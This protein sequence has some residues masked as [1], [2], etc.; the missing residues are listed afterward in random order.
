MLWFNPPVRHRPASVVPARASGAG[1]DGPGCCSRPRSGRPS[2]FC[3]SCGRSD[4]SGGAAPHFVDD[5]PPSGIDHRYDG[6]FEYFVGGGVAA[7]DCDGDGRDELFLAGGTEP[8]ALYHNDSPTGG[9]LRFSAAAVTR[10]RPHRRRPAPTPSTSTAT[11]TT[12]LVVLRRGGDVVLRG[13]GDCRFEPANQQLGIDVPP[14]WTTAFSAT[15]EGTNALPTLAFGRYLVPGQ[16]TCD[17]SWLVRPESASGTALRRACSRSRRATAPC[18]C[19]SAT[20]ATPDTATCASRTTGTTTWTVRSSCAGSSRASL[21][22]STPRPTAGSPCRS[23]AWASP[24]RTSPAT[25]GR[26]CSSPARATTSCRRSPPARPVRPSRT[27]PS[28]AA[29]RRSGPTSAATCC[30]RRPGIP[31]SRT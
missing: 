14:G 10:H 3:P 6:E 8:A 25:G 27:S 23:G 19:C 22:R 17:R 16:D 20:G 7:F 1:G 18:R 4:A 9:A 11:G 2:P 21:R 15:W 13:L 24:A 5:T 29:S 31:S 26:R 12:D 30:R 28:A